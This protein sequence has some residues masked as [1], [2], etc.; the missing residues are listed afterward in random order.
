MNMNIKYQWKWC[1]WVWIFDRRERQSFCL[2]ICSRPNRACTAD[3][4]SNL[5]PLLSR[6]WV[7]NHQ[8]KSSSNK[9]KDLKSYSRFHK[10]WFLFPVVTW[11]FD[12][13]SLLFRLISSW[14][15]VVQWWW[16]DGKVDWTF[17][18]IQVNVKRVFVEYFLL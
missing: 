13:S 14:C 4:L 10:N 2:S 8:I 12:D 15:W 17:L 16:D 9:I 6:L 11:I 7:L 5:S 18:V 1:S 3:M